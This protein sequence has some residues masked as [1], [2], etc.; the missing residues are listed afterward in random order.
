MLSDEALQL[1][2][3]LHLAAEIEVGSDPLFQRRQPLFFQAS[4]F[5]AREESV[6]VREWWTSPERKRIA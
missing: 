4:A 6:E 5:G 2:N 3:E 1:R